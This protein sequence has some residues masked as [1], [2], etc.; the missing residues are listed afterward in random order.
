M[1]YILLVILLSIAVATHAA[2][3]TLN[4]YGWSD[5]MPSEILEQFEKETGIRVNYTTY[6]TNE[7]MYAKLKADPNAAYD[8]VLP[9]TYFIDRMVRQGML[10]K[11]DKSK[12]SNFKNLNPE[13]LNK[14]YDPG[15]NYSLPYAW[16]TTAIVVND[17]FFNPASVTKWADFWQN[18]FSN[19]LLILNDTREVFS[20]A[21]LALGYSVNDTNPDHIKAAYEKL[22]QL[23]SN[24][25]LFNTEAMASIYIDEDAVVGMGWSGAIFRAMQENKN[26]HYT[27]PQE[28]FVVWIDNLAIPKNAKHVAE[29]HLFINFLLRADIAKQISVATGYPTPNL[30]AI[31][32]MPLE[33]QHN[34]VIYPDHATLQRGQL[35]TD[36]GDAVGIYEKYM[37]LLKIGL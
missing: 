29:V 34:Q 8:L 1:K 6:D 16:G 10:Q 20:I 5:Y 17:K 18:R 7:V 22:R 27:Y 15:N 21:L 30:A 33:M 32:L 4:M 31:K 19:H 35:Q 25:R 28:G 23:M 36:V 12:L 37:S 3:S 24:V 2:K 14:S 9:S 26:L 13:L 11:I